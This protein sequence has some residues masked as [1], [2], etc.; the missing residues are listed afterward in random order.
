M[1]GIVVS[2]IELSVKTLD[3]RVQILLKNLNYGQKLKLV[4]KIKI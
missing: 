4:S 1:V 2:K 3:S